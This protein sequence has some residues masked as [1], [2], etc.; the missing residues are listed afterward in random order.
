MRF[1]MTGE[2]KHFLNTFLDCSNKLVGMTWVTNVFPSAKHKDSKGDT[3]VV[4][5]AP[6]IICCTICPLPSVAS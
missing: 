6:I 4:L 3:T 2:L 5:P 1:G